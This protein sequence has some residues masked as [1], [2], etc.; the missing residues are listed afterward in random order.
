[1]GTV[2]G[3]VGSITFACDVGKSELCAGGR[4]EWSCAERCPVGATTCHMMLRAAG[5]TG[6]I[7]S[8]IADLSCASLLTYVC[9]PG[10]ASGLGRSRTAPIRCDYNVNAQ[11]YSA[12]GQ[13][14]PLHLRVPRVLE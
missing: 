10:R 11:E 8:A 2:A 12:H 4:L 13:H 14:W 1:M 7:P 3:R 5:L 6:T 9:A